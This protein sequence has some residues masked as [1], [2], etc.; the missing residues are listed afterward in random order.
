MRARDTTAVDATVFVP[1]SAN[2]SGVDAVLG[3]GK[4]LVSFT[5]KDEHNLVLKHSTLDEGAVPV[6]TA[7]GVTGDSDIV[8]YW[9]LPRE[10]YA[11]ACKRGKPFPVVG[12]N[13]DSTAP[14]RVQQ[15]ALCVPFDRH[16]GQ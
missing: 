2:V 12:L 9:A 1:T 5:I 4:A 10:R 14:H 7:L 8:F 13:P 15:Y 11:I 6:A 16:P 3:H